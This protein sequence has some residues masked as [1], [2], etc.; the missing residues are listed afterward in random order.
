MCVDVANADQADTDGDGVGDACD[1]A[2][3]VANVDQADADNDGVG[4]VADNCI[5]TVNADQA[6]AD[7]DDIGD[8][9]DN[10]VDKANPNQADTDNDGTGDFCEV[11]DVIVPSYDGNYSPTS[12][13]Y[14]FRDVLNNPSDF[15]L[16]DVVIRDD[17]TTA[18]LDDLNRVASEGNLFATFDRGGD[19][20]NIYQDVTTVTDDQEPDLILDNTTTGLDSVSSILL[21][22]GDLYVGDDTSNTIGVFRDIANDIPGGVAV[23]PDFS[24]DNGTSGINDP[25]SMIID[26]NGTL[27][28]A[29]ENDDEV[30][31][32]KNASSLTMAVAP[33][34]VLSGSFFDDPRTVAQIDDCLFVLQGYESDQRPQM[35]YCPIADIET[36]D[37]PSWVGNNGYSF[38]FGAPKSVIEIGNMT[39][40]GTNNGPG[41]IGFETASPPEVYSPTYALGGMGIEDGFR[42]QDSCSPPLP[43]GS[44]DEGA[45]IPYVW[46]SG[47]DRIATC[48]GT[49]LFGA[50]AGP[51]FT[52][53]WNSI[54]SAWMF[55]DP[56]NATD[57]AYPDKVLWHPL[58]DY[59]KDVN[60]I[61][62]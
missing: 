27:W 62:R 44:S 29:D 43:D 50:S 38:N 23:T 45:T 15:I 28:V 60:V 46:L 7:S 16:P 39:W 20:V 37:E 54:T 4:D 6:D 25:W 13:L 47:A 34:I 26:S 17:K 33:D 51:C 57:G 12:G 49:A 55:F 22:D 31:G 18:D 58:M 61:E 10:C 8:V 1:N 48:G 40:F 2:P 53:S 36:G 30:I 35:V 5:N 59:P 32:F 42:V 3:N 21:N 19:F 56:A 52:E 9:C 14:I 24:L 11:C 41:I